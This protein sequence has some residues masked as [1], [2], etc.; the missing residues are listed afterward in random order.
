MRSLV[1]AI[2]L[3]AFGATADAKPRS[4][5][6][7][8]RASKRESKRET[9]REPKREKSHQ[10]T[11]K[12]V[13]AAA[14]R[15]HRRVE[16]PKH[17]SDRFRP[18]PG[19]IYGQSVGAPWSGRLR[20]SAELPRGDGYF[21]RRPWRAYGTSTTVQIVHRVIADIVDRFPDI[22]EI[23]IGDLSAPTGGRISDHNSHQSGRDIDIGLIYK[24]RPPGYPQSFVVGTEQNLDLEVTFV[25]V[26]DF[27]ATAQ[28][29][30]GVQVIFLD[31]DIQ[32]LLYNW[33]RENGESEEYLAK[34]FQYPHGRGQAMG[35]VRHEPHHADHLHI[36]FRCAPADSACR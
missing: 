30:G 29:T 2:S 8:K 24:Q 10:K 4:K 16:Q 13:A 7:E 20:D 18:P 28:E 6:H 27:A 23:A 33:G 3:L 35:I 26:E 17:R 32:R 36:R 21:I 9:K 12:R 19:P 1:V 5:T 22:H 34:L 31:Y 11:K 15:Q 25:L 14:T